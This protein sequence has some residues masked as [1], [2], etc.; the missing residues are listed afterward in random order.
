MF[1]TVS[2][3]RGAL[4]E[5]AV[6]QLPR[7][8]RLPERVDDLLGQAVRGELSGRVSLF[9]RPSDEQLVRTLVNRLATAIIASSL[10]VGAVILLGVHVGPVVTGTV[11]LNEVLGYIGIAA[12]AILIMRVLA[13]VVREEE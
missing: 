3:W 2:S 9:S 7:L 6:A 13:G 5:E 10:G 8:R 11:T 4:E 1:P 12:A